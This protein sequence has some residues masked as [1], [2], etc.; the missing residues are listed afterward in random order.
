MPDAGQTQAAS[1]A[2]VSDAS[3]VPRVGVGVFVL[4]ENGHVLVG[5]RTGS[6]GAGTLALPG[7]HLELHETFSDCAARE[8]LEETGLA[9]EPPNI[10]RSPEQPS[11]PAYP[12][13][14]RPLID[15]VPMQLVT[16]TN[17][18]HIK[19]EGEEGQGRHYV[20]I[21]MKASVR[22]VPG[23]TTAKPVVMEPTKCLGWVW[24]PLAYLR[25]A[26]EQQTRLLRLHRRAVLAG[27]TLPVSLDKLMEAERLAQA[28]R[29]A[30]DNHEPADPASRQTDE[31]ASA[32]DTRVWAEADDFA[33][34]AP[35]FQPLL[36]L[37]S[38]HTD[39]QLA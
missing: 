11:T 8:V 31:I 6:L 21:F 20:T 4:N 9:L 17:T 22:L 12:T 2:G 18:V 19:D 7:G 35:L 16:A 3:V 39:L 38:E 10:V 24:M 32:N 33:Q 30:E 14:T 27:Q 25:Y 26:A 5:K 34:G 36:N 37:L 23:E 13:D 15:P 28:L 29:I 1:F